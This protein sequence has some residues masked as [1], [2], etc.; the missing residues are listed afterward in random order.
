[1]KGKNYGVIAIIIFIIFLLW[2]FRDWLK[3]TFA[4]GIAGSWG[5]DIVGHLSD[6]EMNDVANEMISSYGWTQDNEKKFL[7]E[8][9]KCQYKADFEKVVALVNFKLKDNILS[10]LV[11]NYDALLH[12]IIESTAETT[13]YNE[14]LAKMK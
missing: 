2:Y 5:G 8:V 14:I 4:K 1:M 9:A 6:N 11:P 13:T 7:S 3:V 10:F 12:I